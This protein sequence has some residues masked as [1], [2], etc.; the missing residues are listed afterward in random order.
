[1]YFLAELKEFR[2]SNEEIKYFIKRVKRKNGRK[3]NKKD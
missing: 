1:M 2:A 3:K